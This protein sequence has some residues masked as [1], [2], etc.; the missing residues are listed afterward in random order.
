MSLG[1]SGQ[2]HLC[3]MFDIDKDIHDANVRQ[4]KMRSIQLRVIDSKHKGTF[5][6]ALHLLSD[7]IVLNAVE[8]I[9]LILTSSSRQNIYL[10]WR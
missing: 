4:R 6:K 1:V 9:T 3:Y 5:A 7:I 2:F 10:S 8:I